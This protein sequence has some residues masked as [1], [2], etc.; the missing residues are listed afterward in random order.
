M[1]LLFYS[2][3][4]EHY[5]IRPGKKMFVCPFL[6]NPKFLKTWVADFFL[7]FFVVVV[8]QFFIFKQNC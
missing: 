3:F 7:I 2:N 1:Q 5:S 8:I 6:T 4:P